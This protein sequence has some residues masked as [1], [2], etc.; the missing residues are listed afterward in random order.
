M[1]TSRPGAGLDEN[2]ICNA[3]RWHDRKQQI[4]WTQRRAEL[5]NI[6]QWA[7]ENSREPWDCIVGVSGGKDSTVQ[8]LFVRDELKL[9]PLLVQYSGSDGTDLGR[10]NLENLVDLGFSL[11]SAHPNPIIARKLSLHSFRKFGNLVKF[12]EYALFTAPFRTAMDFSIPLVFFGENP[13]LEAGDVNTTKPG[14]DATGIK[15][16][17]T[18]GGANLDV[19]LD[20]GVSSSDLIPYTYPSDEDFQDWGGKGVFLGYFVDW[21]GHENAIAAIRAGMECIDADV[22]DIGIPYKHNA[23]DSDYGGIVNAMLKHIKLG[24]GNATE[25]SCYDIRD[26]LLSRE[27]AAALAKHLDGRCHP[28]FIQGYCDWVGIEVEEFWRI[29]NSYRGDMWRQLPDN[30]WRMDNPVWEQVAC[31]NVDV[32]AVIRSIDTKTIAS[33][34]R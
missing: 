15:D 7:R 9:S 10:R 8:A 20:S 29:A 19:W 24:F 34:K 26:G 2:G 16:N 27:Q 14:W 6:A 21:S 1:P 3:C 11:I 4:D 5:D 28:R 12:S 13:S 31:E 23:L 25:F 17:N 22:A 33:L 18:L 30:G 32:D